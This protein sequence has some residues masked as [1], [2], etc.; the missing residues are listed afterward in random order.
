M[1]LLAALLVFSVLG[2]LLYGMV[3]PWAGAGP[4]WDGPRADSSRLHETVRALVALGPRH[5]QAGMARAADW[6]RA[7]LSAL[8]VASTTQD[9]RFANGDY[10]NVIVRLGPPTPRR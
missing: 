1:R 7:Q 5:D 2:A 10:R 8:G 6:I 3:Q 4:R 9:Y